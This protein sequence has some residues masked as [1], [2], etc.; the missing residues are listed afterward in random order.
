MKLDK[1]NKLKIM[2]YTIVVIVSFGTLV[3]IP[4]MKP[5][6]PKGELVSISVNLL[7]RTTSATDDGVA[8][9]S[10]DLAEYVG[11]G[12]WL[13]DRG[14]VLITR[15][16]HNPYHKETMIIKGIRSPRKAELLLIDREML[17]KVKR[18]E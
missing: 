10:D 5:S 2:V 17:K 3:A 16:Y 14:L 13:Q 1:R 18:E 7:Y 11:W 8:S 4:F 12:F 15:S 6:H 9:V